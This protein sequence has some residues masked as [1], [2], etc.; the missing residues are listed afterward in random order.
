MLGLT[1]E[2]QAQLLGIGSQEDEMV[3]QVSTEKRSKIPRKVDSSRN[4]EAMAEKETKYHGGHEFPGDSE[5]ELR[6]RFFVPLSF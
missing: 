5:S 2:Q 6:V 4:V 3:R 1:P